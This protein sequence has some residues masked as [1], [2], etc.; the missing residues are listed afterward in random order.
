MNLKNLSIVVSVL[1]FGNSC[2]SNESKST[3]S[4][5]I[6]SEKST[7]NIDFWGEWQSVNGSDKIYITSKTAGAIE[8]IE[9][10]LI[11]LDN[12]YYIRTGDR[13]V[14]F[15]GS[16]YNNVSERTTQGF[17][18]IANIEL[19]LKSAIDT[20]IQETVVSDNNGSFSGDSLPSGKYIITANSND[21]VIDAN[22]TLEKDNDDIGSFQLVSRNLA[23]FK[24]TFE[25]NTEAFYGNGQVYNPTL[26]ISN[27]GFAI[28]KGLNYSMKIDG[29]KSFSRENVLGSIPI[30]GEIRVP[31]TFSFDTQIENEKLYKL[32]ITIGDSS[33]L[34]WSENININVHKKPFILNIVSRSGENLNGSIKL[35]NGKIKKFEDSNL[36]LVLPTFEEDKN[37]ILQFVNYGDL[38]SET[39]YSIAINANP[40]ISTLNDFS[41]TSKFEP[42]EKE[43][44]AYRFGSGTIYSYLHIDDIDLFKIYSPK[45][46]G[47]VATVV[48]P[49]ADF[50]MTM[51]SID[52]NIIYLD[53]SNSKSKNGEIVNY[54][55]VSSLDGELGFGKTLT[56]KELST[57]IHTISLFVTDIYGIV[58]KSSQSL[59]VYY[60]LVLKIDNLMFQDAKLPEAMDWR[61]AMNYCENLNFV[62]CSDWRLPTIEELKIAY[63]HKSEFRNMQ[64][65]YYWSSTISKYDTY[66]S[67]YSWT[68]DFGIGD[69]YGDYLGNDNLFRCVR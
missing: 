57:G 5:T 42:N 43:N 41:E 23:N 36:Q 10:N 40:N 54:R 21:K 13:N 17:E 3:E 19:V 48:D 2:G 58:G 62:G 28:G 49:I 12:H 64:N 22:I 46:S 18:D 24:S 1:M 7:K 14:K 8:N 27:I 47:T 52:T 67:S 68:M 50:H 63:K 11:K 55:W 65:D 26:I 60:G 39:S 25:S 59:N 31:V 51:D 15:S 33:G 4:S 45:S 30:N 9:D 35:P 53:G 34:T 20:N 66:Y 37:Y 56:T 38:K 6:P 69:G 44:K 32:N 29:A 61:D 16:I